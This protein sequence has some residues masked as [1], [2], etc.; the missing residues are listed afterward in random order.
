[1]AWLLLLAASGSS[2]IAQESAPE[3]SL[4]EEIATDEREV[5]YP[6]SGTTAEELRQSMRV[7]GPTEDGRSWYG[8]ATWHVRWRF[9]YAPEPGGC[10]IQEVDVSFRSRIRLP[11]WHPP[12]DADEELVSSW[13][14]FVAALREHEYGHRDIGARAATEILRR[15]RSF[16]WSRCDG[17]SDQANGLAHQILEVHREMERHYDRETDHGER[18]G[19]VWPPREEGDGNG[20]GE[21]AGDS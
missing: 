10:R 2:A 20:I 17:M 18:Q 1:M 5:H 16:R 13:R 19:A 6:V 8:Y 14:T 15:L 4:P 7:S 3:V 12:A 21:T 11:R 9:E